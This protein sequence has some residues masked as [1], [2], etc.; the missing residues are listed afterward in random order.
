MRAGSCGGVTAPHDGWYR[1]P[2]RVWA[3]AMTLWRS[4]KNA[5]SIMERASKESTDAANAAL[6]NAL[7]PPLTEYLQPF[8]INYK[9]VVK[10][11]ALHQLKKKAKKDVIDMMTP[12]ATTGELYLGYIQPTALGNMLRSPSICRGRAWWLRESCR[13]ALQQKWR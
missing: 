4:S 1:L 3:G 8:A 2:R 12:I 5:R 7:P 13:E 9:S 10:M 6:S 11:A